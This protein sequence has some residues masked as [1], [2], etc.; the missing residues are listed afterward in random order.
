M[1]VFLLDLLAA[2]R[3]EFE[4]GDYER[5]DPANHLTITADDLRAAQRAYDAQAVAEQNERPE[6]ARLPRCP[7]KPAVDNCRAGRT[8]LVCNGPDGSLL[9]DQ[10]ALCAVRA[11]TGL[12][13]MRV[14]DV[15]QRK[16]AAALRREH[17]LG[18]PIELLHVALP[19]TPAGIQFA[20]GL[21]DGSW[22]SPRLGR[23]AHPAARRL[24]G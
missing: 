15:T 10:A 14:L 17:S 2:E 20:D 7:A 19:A 23:G 3:K 22:L 24:G 8:L 6:L 11:A 13:F 12:K 1:R 16:F 4:R 18:R 5:D 21:A 9:L